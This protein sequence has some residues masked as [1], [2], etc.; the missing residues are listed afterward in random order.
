MADRVFKA[1]RNLLGDSLL[2]AGGG[3][4]IGGVQ[5]LIFQGEIQSSDLMIVSGND[6]IEGIVLRARTF[7]RVKI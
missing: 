3:D 7:S 6:L 2:L 4:N 1:K 5:G